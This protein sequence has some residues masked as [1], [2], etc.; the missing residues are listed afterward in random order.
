[1]AVALFV[2]LTALDTVSTGNGGGGSP[3][4][5]TGATAR[6]RTRW[7][8][9]AAAPAPYQR[10][11]ASNSNPVAEDKASKIQNQYCP[12]IRVALP[13]WQIT[14]LKDLNPDITAEVPCFCLCRATQKTAN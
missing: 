12:T 7:N 13:K 9:P 6:T 2:G 4:M 1:M 10:T 14:I 5:T 3:T 11:S 8:A